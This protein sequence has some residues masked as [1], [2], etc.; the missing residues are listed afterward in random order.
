M[1]TG[2]TKHL[3]LRSKHFTPWIIFSS[4]LGVANSNPEQMGW[5]PLLFTAS[6][7]V[8]EWKCQS[9]HSTRSRSVHDEHYDD[10]DRPGKERFSGA[11]DG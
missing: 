11:R 1:I 10:W 7:G 5:T 3:E 4:L 2:T 8:P 6:Q 9:N